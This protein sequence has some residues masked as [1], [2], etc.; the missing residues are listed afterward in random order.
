MATHSN[1]LAWRIPWMEEPGR[2]SP[3]GCRVGHD[4]VTSLSLPLWLTLGHDITTWVTTKALKHTHIFPLVYLCLC[5]H[6][7]K[8]MPSLLARPWKRRNKA[9]VALAKSSLNQSTPSPSKL[10]EQAKPL[11]VELPCWAQS[12]CRHMSK[13]AYFCRVLRVC[14]YLSHSLC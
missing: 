10:C 14:G 7:K 1:T 8:Y 9:W 4:W 5:Q 11:S 13:S 12:S 2:F 3:W 6:H